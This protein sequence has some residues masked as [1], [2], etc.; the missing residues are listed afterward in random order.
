M[1]RNQIEIDLPDELANS[2]ARVV[3]AL[4]ITT[5]GEA[6]IIAIA[7]W[8]SRRAAELDNLDPNRRYFVNEALDE[9]IDKKDR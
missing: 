6:A 9:L 4:G 2:L 8:T 3:E 5:L 7:D 1:A